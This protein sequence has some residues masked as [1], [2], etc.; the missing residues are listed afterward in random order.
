MKPFGER[1]DRYVNFFLYALTISALLV[2]AFWFLAGLTKRHWFV[3]PISVLILA[4]YLFVWYLYWQ[5]RP[6]GD[7]R[8]QYPHEIFWT[9][10]GYIIPLASLPLSFIISGEWVL[11]MLLVSLTAWG[12]GIL[13]G[14]LLDPNDPKHKQ[15][16]KCPRP[17]HDPPS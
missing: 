4:I 9:Y 10:V 8:A 7:Q 14:L 5:S 11:R 3:Y 15:S 1:F 13:A 16:S 12:C 6:R 17:N 2:T